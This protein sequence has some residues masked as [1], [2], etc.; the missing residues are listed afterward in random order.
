MQYNSHVV[1][2]QLSWVVR[3]GEKWVVLGGNGTGKSTL[4]EL[5]TGDNV[6]GYQQDVHLFGRKKGSG[7][8]VWEIKAQLGLLSTEFHMAYIDYADPSIRSAF[9]KP[10]KVT[11]WEVVCSGFFD[12]M[13]LYNEMSIEQDAFARDWIDRLGLEDL[14]TPPP[15]TPL[16]IKGATAPSAGAASLSERGIKDGQENFFHL[17]HGQQKLVLLCRAMVKAP[18]LLLLDEPTHGLSGVNKERLLHTLSLLSDDPDVGIV[19]V[20]HRQEEIDALNFEHVLR[21]GPSPSRS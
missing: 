5:I 19:Y 15:L 14:V 7:E 8:S 20:T 1:F 4:V 10:E 21:L 6:L 11:T 9:R 16:G 18:R 2:D 13:G 3:P 17:S 12:S